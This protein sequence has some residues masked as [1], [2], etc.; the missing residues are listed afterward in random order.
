MLAAAAI[1]FVLFIQGAVPFMTTPTVG[2]AV[3]SMGFSQ[4]FAKGALFDFYVHDFGI[5]KPAA[6]AFGLAGAWPA[7][8]LIRLGLNSADAYTGTV[9]LWLAVAMY[10]AYRIGR[11]FGSTRPV[12]I[13]GAVV[14]TTMPIVWAHAGYSMLSL[15]IA[16]LAFYFFSAIKL[17][18]I[19]AESPRITGTTISLYLSAAII[20]IFMDGYTFM[21]FAT[22]ASVLL[23]YCLITRP[24]CRPALIKIALP[25][26]IVSFGLAYALFRAYIGKSN[27]DAQPLD[28]FRGWGLD[29]SFL[30]I[31]T[32]GILWLPDLLGFGVNR[33]D[34][35]YFGDS[36]VWATT[37]GA[38]LL[39]LG[40]VAWWRLRRH[41]RISTG[42]LL[43]AIIGFYM[44][45]GPSL[46]IDSMKPEPLQISLPGSQSAL[47]PAQ[48]AVMPTGTAWI[49]TKLPGFDVMRASYRW[50]A[51]GIFALW[52]LCVIAT[53]NSKQRARKIWL[54]GL[55]ILTLF[56]LPNL[57]DRWRDGTDNRKILQ[58]ID[59]EPVAEL[60]RHVRPGETVAF[61]PWGNDFFANYL[62]PEVGFRTFNIGGDKNLASAQS[63]WPFDMLAA[64]G[65]IDTWKALTAVRMLIDGTADVLVI[66]YFHML[67]SSHLWPCVDQS[68]ARLTDAQK[69]GLRSTPGF[70]CPAKRRA[71]LK[72]IILALRAKPYLDV[73]DTPLF[74]TVRLRAE[75]SGKAN[76]PSLLDML[77]HSIQ[78]P[79]KFGTDTQT[80]P[81]ILA[82]GWH[83]MEAH[84][85]WSQAR[86][87]LRLP[88]PKECE[89]GTCSATLRFAV[90]G[91]SPQRPVEVLFDE[92][93]PDHQWHEKIVLSSADSTDIKV[94]LA[95]KK[96][97]WQDISVSIPDATSPAALSGSSDER[98]L[99]IALQQITLSNH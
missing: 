11:R 24:R 1:L 27:F 5:P 79:L 51:L 6:M 23:L 8:L 99:G 26:H 10:C 4:S 48:Y 31:P 35:L 64:G 21:M 14:W 78:Y 91:A 45:L 38:P 2:Q 97:P 57:Q 50:S 3:W 65:E 95:D 55:F 63:A 44:S 40:L 29:L 74:A 88:I 77:Y 90:F 93:G 9:A 58:Q 67:W 96:N 59:R 39:V 17:F 69:K 19:Q 28:F 85:V 13:L 73:S 92:V 12:S 37:F 32:K 47:M 68:I 56:N 36:S 53:A 54:A 34:K 62:A 20:A 22:G 98:I 70:V 25:A 72:S 66:P 82:S 52:L 86:A 94:P 83:A 15:G 81:Y 30:A 84:H 76:R 43:V 18:L 60:R 49:S 61:I 80:S 41:I 42:V 71:E 7:S 46:K 87:R 33:T 89:T 16:L 75:F